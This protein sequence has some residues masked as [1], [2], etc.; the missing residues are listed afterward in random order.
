MTQT[1]RLI[2]NLAHFSIKTARTKTRFKISLEVG[3]V[4]GKSNFKSAA[5]ADIF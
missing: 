1:V 5:D 2:R 4:L 3:W